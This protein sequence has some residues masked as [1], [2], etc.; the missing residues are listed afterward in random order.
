LKI[1]EQVQRLAVV[2]G[3]LVAA[4][5]V[6]RFVLIPQSLVARELHERSTVEA[7]IAKPVKFAGSAAC[8]DCHDDVVATKNKGRHRNLSCEGCHGPAAAHVADPASGKPTASRD[9]KLC[10]V[11]HAYDAARPT[12]FPQINPTTHN[13]VKPCVSCHNPHD[14][15]PSRPARSCEACHAQIER[16]K[17]VSSHALVPC[18]ACHGVPAGH[19]KDPR[20]VT[21]TKPQAREFCGGCHGKDATRQ[22]TPKID[23]G[24]HGGTYLCWQCHYPHL[25]EGRA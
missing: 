1:P 18:T 14:S 16:T 3:V 4:V 7:E 10:P 19:L 24:T 8:A 15:V 17:A 12:G 21:P 5:L 22:D 23:L 25:P 9:R 13:P 11:C 20:N 2:I 6:T